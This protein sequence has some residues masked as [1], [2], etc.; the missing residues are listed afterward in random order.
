[1]HIFNLSLKY[2][3]TENNTKGCSENT[4]LAVLI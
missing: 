1:M 2:A 3:L 4:M